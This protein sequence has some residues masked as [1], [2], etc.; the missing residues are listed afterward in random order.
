MF[1]ALTG[2]AGGGVS[3]SVS[4]KSGDAQS[5][6]DSAFQYNGQ[7]NVGGSGGATQS[8]TATQDKTSAG[9][10]ASGYGLPGGT[11]QTV[12]YAALAIVGLIAIAAVLG[13][14]RS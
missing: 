1:A 10:G 13:A 5:P 11:N 14:R 7:Q 2:L 3:T 4:S 6:F 9:T 12:V 8:N